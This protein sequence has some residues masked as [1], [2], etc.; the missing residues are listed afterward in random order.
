MTHQSGA[1]HRHEEEG[2]SMSGQQGKASFDILQSY[3][4]SCEICR[5]SDVSAGTELVFPSRCM[6]MKVS[7]GSILEI[8]IRLRDARRYYHQAHTI[9]PSIG[10]AEDASIKCR[11]M[12]HLG[13]P[14]GSVLRSGTKHG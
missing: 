13:V 2:Q 6:S 5:E 3:I 8:E 4:S 7:C 1:S 11:M 12:E 9:S 10:Y 14:G